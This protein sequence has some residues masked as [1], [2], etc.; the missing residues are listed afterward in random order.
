MSTTTG[1]GNLF[2][3]LMSGASDLET[4]YFGAP[5]PYYKYIK[6][7]AEIGMSE[8]GSIAQLGTN[9]KGLIGYADL[10]VSGSGV[11]NGS[12]LHQPLGNNFFIKT[13]GQCKVSKVAL[14]EY[15]KVAIC[16]DVSCNGITNK[17]IMKNDVEVN[18]LVDR[19]DYIHHQ[20]DGSIPFVSSGLG[21]NFGSFKGLIPGTLSNLSVIDPAA[22]FR[23]FTAGPTPECVKL[24]MNT[25]DEFNISK[26]VS[27]YVAV[28]DITSMSPCWF[29]DKINPI[30]QN[31]CREAFQ[32]LSSTEIP[33]DNIV[34]MYFGVL[35]AIF[36]MI[37]Y[38]IFQ[39][40]ALVSL[41]NKK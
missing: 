23:S 26:N 19:Y 10:L 18:T 29:T 34:C 27:Q 20:P 36:M 32:T 17:S 24:N 9:V 8:K 2:D 28:A 11:A 39:K 15:N 12:S 25:I 22:L 3:D 7:P 14:N 6:T 5:Y 21:V 30:T 4:K 16:T 13:A 31:V 38:N 35:F 33:K 37:I 40:N 41:F 1:G